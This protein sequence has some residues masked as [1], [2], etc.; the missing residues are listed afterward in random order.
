MS[1]ENI[2]LPCSRQVTVYMARLDQAIAAREFELSCPRAT[3]AIVR[4]LQA[5]MKRRYK[6]GVVICME[7]EDICDRMADIG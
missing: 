4:D 7:L 1:E 6:D 3:K 2:D 5:V